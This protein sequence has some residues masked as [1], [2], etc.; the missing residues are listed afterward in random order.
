MT[1][2]SDQTIQ[3][4]LPATT[5]SVVGV[6]ELF[7]ITDNDEKIIDANASADAKEP[8]AIE[9]AV[10]PLA[11]VKVEILVGSLIIEWPIGVQPVRACK[12][13]SKGDV[14]DMPRERAIKIGNSVRIL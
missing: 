1:E 5:E 9:A 14:V 12:S 10:E 4:E 2:E 3:E 6:A 8:P 13:F 11:T 7:N